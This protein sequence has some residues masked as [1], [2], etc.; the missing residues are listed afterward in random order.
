MKTNTVN[1][2]TTLDRLSKQE[3]MVSKAQFEFFVKKSKE[4][5]L[6]IEKLHDLERKLNDT[7]K[8]TPYMKN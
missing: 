2:A 4:M 1:D 8:D 5:D 6:N 7:V 3:K